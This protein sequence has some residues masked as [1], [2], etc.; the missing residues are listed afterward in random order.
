MSNMPSYE[1]MQEYLQSYMPERPETFLEMEAYARE[2]DFPIVSPL[3]GHFLYLLARISGARRV[4]ELG[5]GYG[6][7]TAW[8]AKAVTENGGGE[9][10]HVVW[11]QALSEMARVYLSRLG[12]AGMIRFHVAEAVG[13]LAQ[14]EGKFD[15]MFSDINKEAYPASLPVIYEKLKPGG[16]LMVDNLLWGGRVMD[17]H[18]Q[19]ASTLAIRRFA[20]MIANDQHWSQS[21]VPLGD[22]L[23]VA[24]KS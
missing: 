5:S 21:T 11:D 2:H 8:L 22:G 24:Y 14:T 3:A 13:M 10:Y 23:L 9:V 17:A 18:N 6:Y 4:F 12:Y 7:S 1:Q 16:M 20:R 19:A 15:L